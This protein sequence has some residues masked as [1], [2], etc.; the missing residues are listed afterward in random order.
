LRLKRKPI[1]DCEIA[2]CELKS[3]I[4]QSEIKKSSFNIHLPIF[5]DSIGRRKGALNEINFLESEIRGTYE[6]ALR[7]LFTAGT[8]I[9]DHCRGFQ[10]PTGSSKKRKGQLQTGIEELL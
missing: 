7:G 2:D 3:V 9:G 8:S 5:P 1:A 10:P 4:P 6:Q